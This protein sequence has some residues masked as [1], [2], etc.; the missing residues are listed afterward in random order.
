MEKE[1]VNQEMETEPKISLQ[2]T[3][4]EDIP[5]LIELEKAAVSK[6]YSGTTTEKEWQKEIEKDGASVYTII[7]DGQIVGD[8]SYEMRDNDTAYISGL[9]VGQDFAGQGIG[10]E[11]MRLMLEELKDKRKIEL[12]T[13]PENVN[14]IRIYKSLGFEQVGEP[15]ENYFGDGEPRIRMVLNKE[16]SK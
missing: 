3:T 1:L 15:I 10:A 4:T 11:A 14:A 2:E 12:V 5:A 6:T 8:A 7:R 16:I 13:H 9:C